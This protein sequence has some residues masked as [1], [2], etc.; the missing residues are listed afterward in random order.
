MLS[1]DAVELRPGHSPRMGR[2]RVHQ[3]R[4]LHRLEPSRTSTTGSSFARNG[5]VSGVPPGRLLWTSSASRAHVSGPLDSAGNRKN[6]SPVSLARNRGS[7]LAPP[8]LPV[9]IAVGDFCHANAAT[10]Q[11]SRE[12]PQIASNFRHVGLPLIAPRRSPVR[13]RLAPSKSLQ[14]PQLARGRFGAAAGRVRLVNSR[15]TS[16]PEAP[17]AARVAIP[18]KEDCDGIDHPRPRS[19][20]ARHLPPA[21]R[22]VRGLLA[23]RRQAALQD[24]WVRNPRQRVW[25][26]CAVSPLSD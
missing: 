22:Q 13:V 4:V 1:R 12:L 5:A 25:L 15:S 26:A 2:S 6:R 20:R 10:C 21:E 14:T 16:R 18:G 8:G 11:N 7:L 19:R 3:D 23:P 9:L 24:R 17:L